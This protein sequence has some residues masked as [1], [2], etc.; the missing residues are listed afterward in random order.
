MSRVSCHKYY[1]IPLRLEHNSVTDGVLDGYP[2]WW[3]WIVDVIIIFWG[4][5][6]RYFLGRIYSLLFFLERL[7]SKGHEGSIADGFD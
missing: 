2:Y 5:Q 1:P 7:N 4:D 3:L 6:F